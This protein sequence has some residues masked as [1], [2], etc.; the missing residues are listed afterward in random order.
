MDLTCEALTSSNS[1]SV[2]ENAWFDYIC[3]NMRAMFSSTGMEITANLLGEYQ[4]MPDSRKVEYLT[5][6]KNGIDERK[7]IDYFNFSPVAFSE[8]HRRFVRD[9]NRKRHETIRRIGP[10]C[11]KC[12]S[13]N[14]IMFEKQMRSADEGTTFITVC[15]SCG[16]TKLTHS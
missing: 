8:T 6:I 11:V 10:P 12:K 4:A 1:L 3:N 7:G 5:Y 2:E 16:A 15:G 13:T 9:M 14:T